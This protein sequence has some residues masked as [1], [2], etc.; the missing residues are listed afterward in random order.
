MT[1]STAPSP[2]LTPSTGPLGSARA[3]GAVTL[4]FAVNG[5]VLGGWGGSLPSLR[6]KLAIGDG[7]VALMLFL[8]GIA[9]T[10]K[11]HYDT[12]VTPDQYQFLE[13]AF[14]L[15]AVVL[16]G[17]GTVLGVILGAT[18]LE[19]VPE[20]LRFVQEYRMLLFGLL[21]VVMMRFRP[22]GLIPNQRRALEFHSDDEELVDEVEDDLPYEFVEERA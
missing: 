12:S 17:M 15:A 11:A 2:T 10:V 16:G 7:Q 4:M 19:L 9:G 20:K 14:L 8:A 21:M 3:R 13:S 1:A 6:D 5:L 18:L 22:E